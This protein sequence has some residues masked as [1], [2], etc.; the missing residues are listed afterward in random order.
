MDAAIGYQLANALLAFEKDGRYQ[1]IGT[2][3]ELAGRITDD[4]Y[5][6][7]WAIGIPPGCRWPMLYT[8]NGRS[9][10]GPPP[11]M[12]TASREANRLRMVEQNC[13]FRAIDTLPRN[14]GYVKLDG[15]MEPSAC[16]ETATRAMAA[17]NNVDALIIDLR[18]NGGGMGET[19]LQIAGH[20][21]DRPAFLYDP[22]PHSRVPS[23]TAS[24]VPEG[25][26]AD[27]P[28]YLLTTARTASAAEYFVYNLKMLKRVTIV[29]E[30]TAG[31]IHSGTSIRSTIPSESASGNGAAGQSLL[32]K[33]LGGHRHRAPR[34]GA[35]RRSRADRESAG[36]V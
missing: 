7:S 2:G 26:L 9:L 31:K 13:L 33:G 24:P 28:V 6:T 8:A 21:F 17:V 5:E 36:R 23:H 20:L 4:I 18:D 25:R 16:Q 14:I 1:R 35:G 19:A 30:R 11:P 29:G 22:R 15:F 12:T 34:A 32:S 27:K 3:V 10:D